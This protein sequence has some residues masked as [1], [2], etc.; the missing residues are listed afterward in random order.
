[1]HRRKL[2]NGIYLA[3]SD[4]GDGEEE[5]E[6]EEEPGEDEEE[7]EETGDKKKKKDE[8]KPTLTQKQFNDALA[9]KK[10][11]ELNKFA[12]KMGFTSAADMEKDFADKKK[13]GNGEKTDAEKL[14]EKDKETNDRISASELKADR[15]EAKSYAMEEHGVPGKVASKIVKLAETYDDDETL[16]DRVDSVIEDFAD[17]L[18]LTGK[19][20]KK[21]GDE[22]E[23]DETEDDDDSKKKSKNKKFGS[24][25]KKQKLNATQKAT[26]DLRE[27]MGLPPEK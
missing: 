9:K 4:E 8:E 27:S 15:A 7:E 19:K 16:E 14:A 10:G 5:E 20:K 17:I 21:K 25:T 13:K 6:E 22:D 26:N 18:D 1:M 2:I 3:K 23:D 12:R 11:R 24:G